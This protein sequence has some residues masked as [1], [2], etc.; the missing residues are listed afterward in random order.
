MNSPEQVDPTSVGPETNPGPTPI[1]IG[2]LLVLSGLVTQENLEGAVS[3]SAK[4]KMPL[5]RILSMHGHLDEELLVK[6]LEMLERIRSQQTT[7]EH[8]LSILRT[9]R[10]DH[11]FVHVDEKTNTDM[12]LVN[13]RQPILDA[14]KKIGAVSEKQKE[15]ARQLSEETGLPGGWVLLGQGLITAPLLNAAIVCQRTIENRYLT[16]E[17]AMALLRVARMNQLP[18]Q[19]VLEQEGIDIPPLQTELIKCHLFL[20]TGLVNSSEMLACQELASILHLDMEQLFWH[21][22][23]LEKDAYE[24][25]RGICAQIGEGLAPEEAYEAIRALTHPHGEAESTGSETLELLKDSRV[26]SEQD[27]NAA[28]EKAYQQ[29]QPLLKLLL[30]ENLITENVVNALNE[31]QSLLNEHCITVNQARILVAYCADTKR[32]VTSA[33]NEFGWRGSRLISAGR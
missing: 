25:L 32:D 5:G 11:T 6:S 1:R 31:C 18:F 14:L 24:S 22:G 9:L 17:K 26:L 16:E 21:V 23:L 7:L 4:L 2:E 20:D 13:K 10:D 29:R 33:L 12:Q 19:K 15:C 8:G 27:L 30:A 28:A 3:L